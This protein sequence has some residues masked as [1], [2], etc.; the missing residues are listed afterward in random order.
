MLELSNSDI[1]PQAKFVGPPSRPD[2]QGI[3]S[4]FWF[5][6]I[7]M[8]WPIL[9]IQGCPIIIFKKLYSFANCIILSDDLI[10]PLQTVKTLIKRNIV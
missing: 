2:V 4:F 5:Y 8:G 10:L 7:N 9:H 3:Y 6:P 1:G